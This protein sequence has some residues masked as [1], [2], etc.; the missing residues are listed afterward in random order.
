M[1]ASGLPKRSEQS[2]TKEYNNF[3]LHLEFPHFAMQ[4][5]GLSQ[6]PV[7]ELGSLKHT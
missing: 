3:S 2:S 5:L 7:K 4:L 1:E 6:D